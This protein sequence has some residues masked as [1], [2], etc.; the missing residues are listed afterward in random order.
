[1]SDRPGVA[2][3]YANYIQY[4]AFKKGIKKV[5]IQDIAMMMPFGVF[6]KDTLTQAWDLQKYPGDHPG[7]D[8]MLDYRTAQET[9]EIK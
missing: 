5:G 9:I 7:S 2:V 6:S 3:I 4:K 8:N 1:M